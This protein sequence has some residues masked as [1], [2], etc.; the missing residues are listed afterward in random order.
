MYYSDIG[1]HVRGQGGKI[2]MYEETRFICQHFTLHTN[3]DIH[4][5]FLPNLMLII[6]LLITEFSY[7]NLWLYRGMNIE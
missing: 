6:N 4:L 7:N 2:L 3:F 1:P 5:I